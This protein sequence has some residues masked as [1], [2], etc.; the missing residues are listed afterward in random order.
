MKNTDL[1]L[2]AR[3]IHENAKAK[4]FWDTQRNPG[5]LFMLIVSE[6][7]EALEAHRK[8]RFANWERFSKDQGGHAFELEDK[9]WISRF[10]SSIKDTI[11][12]EIAD[13][14]IRILDYVGFCGDLKIGLEYYAEQGDFQL[15]QNNVGEVLMEV[16]GWVNEAYKTTNRLAF[17]ETE[18]HRSELEA[19]INAALI[20][21]FNLS[22]QCEFQLLR[23]INAKMK[24]NS[25]RERLHGKK[26]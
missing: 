10:Q 7:G 8:G 16:V 11:E 6:L 18:Q 9:R 24:F 4:G 21:L 15:F 14:V 1:N 13:T 20:L 12:D 25:T 3:E 22:V 17:V 26:Y 23:H 5:E 19:Q 2:L